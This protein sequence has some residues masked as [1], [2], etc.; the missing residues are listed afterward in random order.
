M[1][2]QSFNPEEVEAEVQELAT[3][4]R[5]ILPVR[6]YDLRIDQELGT[7]EVILNEDPKEWANEE[8]ENAQRLFQHNQSIVERS[9]SDAIAN[10]YDFDIVDDEFVFFETDIDQYSM[11]VAGRLHLALAE[12]AVAIEQVKSLKWKIEYDDSWKEDGF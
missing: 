12:L 7:L 1:D 8:I 3:E 9:M 4:F 10:D 6:P 11:S 2:K 5:S